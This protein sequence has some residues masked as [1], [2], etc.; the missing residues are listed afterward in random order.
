MTA[1][2]ERPLRVLVADDHP[3][4]RAVIEIILDLVSA[5]ATS[6]ENGQQ[7]LMAF[8]TEDFD[9]VL[10]D[11]QMPVMD[12]LTAIREIRKHEDATD[13]PRTPVL[14]V[15]ANA[16]SEHVAASKEAGADRHIAKPVTPEVLLAAISTELQRARQ[17][18]DEARVKARKSEG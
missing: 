3:T 1:H 16:L 12:G 9:V 5:A 4:N 13:R 15:T 7:A 11:L 18:L 2:A 8:K 14:A 10:M 17:A 6:V